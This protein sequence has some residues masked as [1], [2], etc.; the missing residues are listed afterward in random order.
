MSAFSQFVSN[1]RAKIAFSGVDEETALYYY[2]Y[3]K[4]GNDIKLDAQFGTFT[5]MRKVG[6]LYNRLMQDDPS[7]AEKFYRIFNRV[8]ADINALAYA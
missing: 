1:L 3:D 4:F 6:P 5:V 8:T 2:V 7:A